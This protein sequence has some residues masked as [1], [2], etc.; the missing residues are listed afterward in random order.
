MEALAPRGAAGVAVLAVAVIVVLWHVVGRP[1]PGFR[2]RERV[3]G[4]PASGFEFGPHRGSEPADRH[5][6]GI[7]HDPEGR[8]DRPARGRPQDWLADL[9]GPNPGSPTVSAGDFH[10]S[11]EEPSDRSPDRATEERTEPNRY[12]VD[13]NPSSD[14]EA[15]GDQTTAGTATYRADDDAAP[16]DHADRDTKYGPVDE[17]VEAVDAS[18]TTS[19]AATERI[20][21]AVDRSPLDTVEA[22]VPSADVGADLSERFRQRGSHVSGAVRLSVDDLRADQRRLAAALAGLDEGSDNG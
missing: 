4:D 3:D 10:R 7:A 11:L 5:P 18:R 20:R 9:F 8:S 17:L 6:S 2:R 12:A 16:T 22:T 21:R 14:T 15:E 1:R 13:R 19:D